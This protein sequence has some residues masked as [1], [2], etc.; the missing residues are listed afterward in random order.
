M[1]ASTVLTTNVSNPLAV[2]TT[3]S[4][5]A[6]SGRGHTHIVTGS[7]PVATT[8][9]D[10]VGDAIML[11]NL[12]GTDTLVSLKLYISTSMDT[13]GT[14]TLAHNLGLYKNVKSDGTNTAVSAACYASAAT[15]LRT[16]SS[17]GVAMQFSARTLD[18]M[19]QAVYL[20][21]GETTATSDIRTVGIA[22][23]AVS[24]T[25]ASGILAYE[26]VVQRG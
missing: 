3:T 7:V 14:P 5:L 12:R 13:N 2:P 8:S 25:A 22:V 17:T 6:M 21:G 23:S 18:K 19:G 9:L 16:A 26:A 1:T 20:D 4:S 24:A 10:D 11:F 15:T